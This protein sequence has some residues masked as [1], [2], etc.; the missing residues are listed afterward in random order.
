LFSP[1]PSGILKGVGGE[2]TDR[3]QGA[4]ESGECAGG[5]REVTGAIAFTFRAGTQWM[6]LPE[7]YGDR[8]GVFSRLPM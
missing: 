6:Y 5:H 4:V 1:T 7:R 8:W 3:Q 2:G